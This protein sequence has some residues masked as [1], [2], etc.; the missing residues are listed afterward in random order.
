[1]TPA[2]SHSHQGES[3]T[4]QANTGDGSHQ[5]GPSAAGAKQAKASL[6]FGVTAGLIHNKWQDSDRHR[7]RG[8]QHPPGP[9]Q[10]VLHLGHR[11]TQ[12]VGDVGVAQ[13]VFD[14]QQQGPASIFGEV[15]DGPLGLVIRL[16]GQQVE[17]RGAGGLGLDALLEGLTAPQGAT[18]PPPLFR[19]HVSGDAEQPWTHSA[20]ISEGLSSRQ[21]SQQG[22][23]GRVF[24][25]AGTPQAPAKKS[26]EGRSVGGELLGEVAG[27]GQIQKRNGHVRSVTPEAPW[28]H[29]GVVDFPQSQP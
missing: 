16:V 9:V 29:P 26:A 23:L 3:S 5:S 6:G 4:S 18:G 2:W 27:P 28:F 19:D 24:G 12:T 10:L 20:R 1:V 17:L 7:Q 14:P 21:G 25:L 15:E 22:L 13:L 8:L 11:P